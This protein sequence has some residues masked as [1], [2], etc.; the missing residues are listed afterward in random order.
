MIWSIIIGFPI[1][2]TTS[3]PQ[4]RILAKCQEK[5]RKCSLR[6]RLFGDEAKK[7]QM[8]KKI[9][10]IMSNSRRKITLAPQ[11]TMGNS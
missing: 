1:V 11:E 2:M 10:K 3:Q 4:R 6:T 7:T 9:L 5:N 8:V